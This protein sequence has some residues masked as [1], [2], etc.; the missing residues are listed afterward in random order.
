MIYLIR[1]GQTNWNLEKRTQ[2]HIDV[3]LNENGK[4]EAFLITKKIS[5]IEIDQIFSSDLQ[6]AQ[7]TAQIINHFFNLPIIYDK[8]LRE[9][10]Y[11]QF[12]GRLS[13]D[14]SEQEWCLFNEKPDKLNA[15]SKQAVYN[16]VKDFC[17]QLN[18]TKNTLIITHGGIIR[19][20]LYCIQN[21]WHFN[22][23]D[24]LNFFKQT[25]VGNTFIFKWDGQKN[26]I[27]L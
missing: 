8:R 10:N 24:F 14:I 20:M 19:M 1:H 27:S 25:A 6:R 18:K 13:Q 21:N 11:G 17:L 15:E 16:R 2:G 3:P 12:E 5:N 9:F 4:K 7:Q 23:D 22:A 26:I